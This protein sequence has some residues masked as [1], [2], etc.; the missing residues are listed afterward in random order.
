MFIKNISYQQMIFK[1]SKDKIYDFVTYWIYII[2]I[3]LTYNISY[4]TIW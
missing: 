3:M 4:D 2:F 1:L